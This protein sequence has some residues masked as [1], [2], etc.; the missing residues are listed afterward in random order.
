MDEATVYL[1]V[2]VVD[3]VPGDALTHVLLLL[4]LEDEGDESAIR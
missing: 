3:M 2:E 1:V 4:L